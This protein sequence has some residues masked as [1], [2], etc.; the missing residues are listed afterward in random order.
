MNKIITT[1]NNTFLQR[2]ATYK[3]LFHAFFYL[4]KD[5]KQD[6]YFNFHFIDVNPEA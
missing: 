5:G 6:I 2:Y 1:G 4:N 3:Y